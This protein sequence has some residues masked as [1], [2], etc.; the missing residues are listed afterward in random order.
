MSIRTCVIDK[1]VLYYNRQVREKK[2]MQGL[3]YFS[4]Y[5]TMANKT[6]IIVKKELLKCMI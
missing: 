4:A 1:N 3:Q 5:F 2:N 6:I